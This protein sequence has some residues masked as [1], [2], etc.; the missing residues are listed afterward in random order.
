MV[1][2]RGVFLI[3]AECEEYQAPSCE[4]SSEIR[5][6]EDLVEGFVISAYCKPVSFE[7][8]AEKKY[9]QHCCQ[10]LLLRSVITLF[11]AGERVG[12]IAHRFR[13]AARLHLQADAAALD[14]ACV[15]AQGYAATGVW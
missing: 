13:S 7:V 9:C 1:N 5:K 3:K 11:G 10:A 4:W 14:V 15:C 12:P 2:A 8:R 6:N